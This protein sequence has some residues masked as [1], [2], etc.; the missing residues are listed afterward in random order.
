MIVNSDNSINSP[1]QNRS[2]LLI[3]GLFLFFLVFK[4]LDIFWLTLDEE[5]GDILLSKSFSVVLIIFLLL[6]MG[7]TFFD[8]GIKREHF[9][10]NVFFSLSFVVC[11][12]IS[13]RFVYTLVA[14]DFTAWDIFDVSL[15]F[16][17]LT[18][19]TNIVNVMME[20]SLFRGIFLRLSLD[21][22]KNHFWRANLLQAFFFG[23]WHFP[24]PVKE[25]V[26]GEMVLAETIMYMCVLCTLSFAVALPWGY[27]YYKTS[28]IVPSLIWHLFWNSTLGIFPLSSDNMLAYLLALLTGTSIALGSIPLF[29][30][31]IS[32]EVLDTLPPWT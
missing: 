28:S 21:A 4:M 14:W 16:L 23:I 31:I 17:Y 26:L 27:Y 13:M 8:I 3:I 10:Y 25:Y 12:I 20:E 11:S 22:S 19:V 32:P 5:W 7:K 29:D 6:F 30:R 1:D 18:F 9:F 2:L 15:T 24:T